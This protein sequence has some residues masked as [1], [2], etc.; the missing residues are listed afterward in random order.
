MRR[1]DNLG[2]RSP[3]RRSTLRQMDVSRWRSPQ[4]FC[5]SPTSS[6]LTPII[7]NTFQDWTSSFTPDRPLRQ[8]V[9]AG[10]VQS[11]ATTVARS[12][13][14]SWA[15]GRYPHGMTDIRP[16]GPRLATPARGHP[17][18]DDVLHQSDTHE[19]PSLSAAHAI[20]GLYTYAE[21]RVRCPDLRFSP[22]AWTSSASC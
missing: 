10:S 3:I 6:L 7:G 5:S 4:N 13:G 1:D 2:K 17:R 22:G 11:S 15:H 14:R 20:A 8:L 9:Q 16:R 21:Q 19:R 12:G 18:Q